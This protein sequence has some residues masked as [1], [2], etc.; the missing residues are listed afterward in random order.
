MGRIVVGVDG[1]PSSSKALHWAL[2]EARR[3]GDTLE[4]LHAWPAPPIA[5]TGTAAVTSMY[6]FDET[7]ILRS[8][9]EALE[10]WVPRVDDAFRLHDLRHF[11][12]T[13]MLDAGIPLAVVARRLDHRRASTT[14]D[15]YAHAVPGRDAH[16]ARTLRQIL[17]GAPAKG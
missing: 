5:F 12:A 8:L 3:R 17:Q 14:L 2:D 10:R 1:S 16:A 11:M 15:R 13:Q 9:E 7:S 4:V 6:T